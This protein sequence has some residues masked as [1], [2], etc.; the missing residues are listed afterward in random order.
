MGKEGVRFLL[1]LASEGLR[2]TC[3]LQRQNFASRRDGTLLLANGTREG[4]EEGSF[5]EISTMASSQFFEEAL[6]LAE[7]VEVCCLEKEIL[8]S[9][10]DSNRK[11]E[12]DK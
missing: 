3:F 11:Q 1:V 10:N 12:L 6:L 7:T 5:E 9:E 8:L 4:F 2:G